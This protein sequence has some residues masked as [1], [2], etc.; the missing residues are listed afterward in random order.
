MIGIRSGGKS[1]E[2]EPLSC[3]VCPN[4]GWLLC[5][6]TEW[7]CRTRIDIQSV[8]GLVGMGEKAYMYLVSEVLGVKPVHK[9]ERGVFF[10]SS[11]VSC[12]RK[13]LGGGRALFLVVVDQTQLIIN[14]NTDCA[15]HPQ[16]IHPHT[17]VFCPH[18]S[19]L[20]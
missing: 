14:I 20:R 1:Y 9:G 10:P 13:D 12:T 8:G 19:P 5:I 6:R 11:C 16:E 2:M 15:S 4:S 3:G 17:S 7:N 18:H